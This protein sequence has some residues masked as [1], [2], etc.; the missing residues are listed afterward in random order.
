M[1]TLNNSSATLEVL[2]E[3]F[4]RASKASHDRV[5]DTLQNVL[6]IL[7]VTPSGQKK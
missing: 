7:N 3:D 6:A 2:K 5:D 1:T 4:K